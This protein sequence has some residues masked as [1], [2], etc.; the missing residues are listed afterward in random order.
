MFVQELRK[1][2]ILNGEILVAHLLDQPLPAAALSQSATV[3]AFF[4]R[5]G[6]TSKHDQVAQAV[7]A[8]EEL[9]AADLSKGAQG[10]PAVY[11]CSGIC[12]RV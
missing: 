1:D 9:A 7:Q 3:Q 8:A 11:G 2:A 5:Q 6:G 12:F 4:R 10:C